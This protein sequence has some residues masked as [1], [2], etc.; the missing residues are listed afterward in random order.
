ML[1]VEPSNDLR[2][3]RTRLLDELRN[4]QP[5]QADELFQRTEPHL[6][7][8]SVA[9]AFWNLLST[10]DLRWTDASHVVATLRGSTNP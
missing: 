7:R 3:A 10:G 6:G 5:M 8:S 1:V 9:V 4:G 2:D